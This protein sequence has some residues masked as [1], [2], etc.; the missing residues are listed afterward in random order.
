MF[1]K[2]IDEEHTKRPGLQ[3]WKVHAWGG[4]GWYRCG[5][6]S[7][8]PVHQ[9]KKQI[10][11]AHCE[12]QKPWHKSWGK[13]IKCPA[14]R[15][16]DGLLILVLN[17]GPW[18]QQVNLLILADIYWVVLWLCKAEFK[19]YSDLSKAWRKK[20][21]IQHCQ[22][23]CSKKQI[24]TLSAYLAIGKVVFVLLRQYVHSLYS[25]WFLQANLMHLQHFLRLWRHPAGNRQ[26]RTGSPDLFVTL[27]NLYGMN[28][29]WYIAV[30]GLP[31]E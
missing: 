24:N 6:E 5:R 23:H 13:S 17:S 16:S 1:C 8:L 4:G 2:L 31:L 18:C 9:S 22:I 15:I 11:Y 28:P 26:C 10:Q 3:L 14:V 7:Y 25:V 21:E 27:R 30:I 19:A 29:I 12:K 20:H